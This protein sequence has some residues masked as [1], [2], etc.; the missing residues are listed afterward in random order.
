MEIPWQSNNWDYAFPQQGAWV[1][2]PD[3]KLGSH[4]LH[5]AAKKRPGEGGGGAEVKAEAGRYQMKDCVDCLR[6]GWG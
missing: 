2:S 5:G 6:R 3:R 4:K 1:L